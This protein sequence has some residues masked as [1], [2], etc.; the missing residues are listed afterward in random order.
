VG[1]G[2]STVT[3]ASYNSSTSQYMMA[4]SDGHMTYIASADV[5]ADVDGLE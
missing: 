3:A 2:T 4:S 5:G 1:G